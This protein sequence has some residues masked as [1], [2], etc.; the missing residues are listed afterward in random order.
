[1]SCSGGFAN[2]E[3]DVDA[4][5]N[6]SSAKLQIWNSLAFVSTLS[7]KRG[8]AVGCSKPISGRTSGPHASYSFRESN[9][10]W[11]RSDGNGR[12]RTS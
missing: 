7:S 8:A 10:G 4:I 9:C 1:M 12:C 11:F 3:A 5:T 2:G 6:G